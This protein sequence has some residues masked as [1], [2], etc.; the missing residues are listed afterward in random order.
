ML[1]YPYKNHENL[2]I[3]FK[4]VPLS[5]MFD[6]NFLLVLTIKP[7]STSDIEPAETEIEKSKK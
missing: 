2:K 7:R 1:L 3:V 6:V 4:R 5:W